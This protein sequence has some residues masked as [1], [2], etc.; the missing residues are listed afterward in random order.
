MSVVQRLG[1]ALG[2]VPLVFRISGLLVLVAFVGGQVG[3]R[4]SAGAFTRTVLATS[5]SLCPSVAQR[6]KRLTV[7]NGAHT[8]DRAVWRRLADWRLPQPRP[9]CRLHNQAAFR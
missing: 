5:A 7:G 3:Q 8:L 2:R 9:R 6:N 4:Q 1:A